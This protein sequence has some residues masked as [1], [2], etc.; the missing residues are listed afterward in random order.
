MHSARA[1]AYRLHGPNASWRTR[2]AEAGGGAFL[3][4]G[5]PFLDLAAWLADFPEPVRISATMWRPRGVGAVEDS[6][7]VLIEATN[8]FNL[9]VDVSWTYGGEADRWWFEVLGT[10]GSAR[11]AP[12]RIVKSLNGRP[13]NVTPTGA[14]TRESPFLQSYRAELAH[15]VAVLRG[16]AAY[17]APD[18]Q[19]LVYRVLELIYKA[20]E[21]GKEIRP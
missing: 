21:D 18:D 4:H 3:E 13:T 20:A 19:L 16:A 6:M 14:S 17:E 8:G 15:F 7:T 11:L 12:L 2:R 9:S 1:G 10:K 5:L